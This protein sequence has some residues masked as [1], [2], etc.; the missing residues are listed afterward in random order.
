MRLLLARLLAAPVIFAAL[1]MPVLAECAPD[2][3]HLKSEPE[4]YIAGR[5]AT[6]GIAVIYNGGNAI[7]INNKLN[8]RS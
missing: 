2:L 7:A 1:I 4:D 3:A 8:F 6:T 5:N